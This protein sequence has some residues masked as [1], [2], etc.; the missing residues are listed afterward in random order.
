MCVSVGIPA[1]WWLFPFNHHVLLIVSLELVMNFVPSLS[2]SLSSE[3]L[4]GWHPGFKRG[5]W[6]LP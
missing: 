6:G 2:L 3:H 5:P 4:S 1:T